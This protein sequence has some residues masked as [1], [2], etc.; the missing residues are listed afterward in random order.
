[1][2]LLIGL[3]PICALAIACGGGGDGGGGGGGPKPTPTSTPIT[4]LYVRT[5]GSDD[6]TGASPNAALQTVARAAQLV[7]PGVTVYVGP[8]TYAG[9]VKIS[10][11]RSSAMQPVHLIADP[12]GVHTRDRVPGEVRI[13]GDNGDVALRVESAAAVTI[14]GFV[15]G[16]VTNGEV[17]LAMSSPQFAIRN[18]QVLETTDVIGIHLDN[19]DDALVFNNVIDVD[20]VGVQTE[21]SDP[22]RIISNTIVTDQATAIRIGSQSSSVT[23][24][25]NIVDSDRSNV[26][27]SIEDTARSTYDGDYNLVFTRALRPDD[28]QSAYRP[29]ELRGAHDINE[30]ALFVDRDGGNFQLQQESP[31]I[32]AGNGANVDTALL[33]ELG[34]RST[35]EDGSVDTPPVDLGFH[36]PAP[37]AE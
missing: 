36:Y 2:R 25:N 13:D 15:I 28:Q 4:T 17:V 33:I 24:R 1:M 12:N 10:N 34:N 19:A 11:T 27:I 29:Q 14:D 30:E 37:A 20:G 7:G 18:C 3:L 35:A 26:A 5:S 22:I 32:D 31:A 21:R 6:N 9:T 16:G 8:G 23:V